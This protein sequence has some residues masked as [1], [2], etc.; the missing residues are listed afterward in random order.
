MELSHIETT[1]TAI[2]CLAPRETCLTSQ[3]SMLV[4]NSLLLLVSL[5]VGSSLDATCPNKFQRWVDALDNAVTG[6]TIV[7]FESYGNGFMASRDLRAGEVVLRIPMTHV[8]SN[9]KE[10]VNG[11]GSEFLFNS[12]KKADL[13]PLLVLLEIA[14]CQESDCK[15]KAYFDMLPVFIGSGYL[16]DDAA[17]NELQD[18]EFSALLKTN[19]EHKE[20]FFVNRGRKLL[21]NALNLEDI[22]ARDGFLSMENYF[23][24]TSLC[25]SRAL[26]IEGTKY[27]VP[28]ADMFN[29]K[30]N[31]IPRR[32]ANGNFFKDHHF[33]AGDRFI[34]KADRSTPSGSQVFMDYGDNPNE[35]YFTYHGFVPHFNPHD[36]IEIKYKLDNSDLKSELAKLVAGATDVVDCVSDRKFEQYPNFVS[37]VIRLRKIDAFSEDHV[38]Q[39]LSD[40]KKSQSQ[41]DYFK[42]ITRCLSDSK[43]ETFLEVSK[44]LDQMESAYSSSL[45]AD[46]ENFKDKNFHQLS[47]PIQYRI[48]RKQLIRDTLLYLKTGEFAEDGA[49]SLQ[50]AGKYILSLGAISPETRS[51]EDDLSLEDKTDRLNHWVS[52]QGFPLVKIKAVPIPGIRVGTIAT[53]TILIESPYLIVP[54]HVV[55]N[56]ETSV[57]SNVFPY[58]H[59]L[60]EVLQRHDSFHQLLVFLM[61]ENF[62][63][64]PK[65]FW[66]PYL[67]LLPSSQ[68]MYPPV[69]YSQVQLQVL[70]RHPITTKI[71]KYREGIEK[72][73]SV[74]KKFL[75]D[76]LGDSMLPFG[77]FTY[78]NYL[79]A[80]AIL[81]SRAIWWN[82]QRHLVPL[83]DLVNCDGAISSRAH[84]T[85]DMPAL[86]GAV[87]NANKDYKVGE[88][89]FENYGQPNHVYF[90]WHGFSL[91]HNEFD[92]IMLSLELSQLQLSNL[93]LFRSENPRIPPNTS[94][95]QEF[96]V[97]FPIHSNREAIA[98]LGSAEK[99]KQVVSEFLSQF[100]T[101]LEEN[102]IKLRSVSDERTKNAL[103]FLIREKKLLAKLL[104]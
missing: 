98:T 36:C 87:T 21:E 53:E 3:D 8:L 91:E 29:Y 99:L 58:L 47:L 68:E 85:L 28:I 66:W 6:I 19:K 101:P 65:S 27:L 11:P 15:W 70:E 49:T 102:Q 104:E 69:Y 84:S 4:L 88:Q 75:L 44:I 81:D 55:M 67:S 46:I 12:A 96:C 56:L 33:I 48:K 63:M 57:N 83:L 86:G 51:K 41:A 94:R 30:S 42:Y 2:V 38:I 43:A 10:S 17:L 78:E 103:T 90:M 82:G 7:G 5:A 13:L 18:D 92:C 9:T 1:S 60:S 71:I 20:F 32:S 72:K 31:P 95:L 89:V 74:V 100:S 14:K 22:Q 25:D 59:H 37:K 26:T 40:I 79:W 76:H 52:S 45:E 93:F 97:K 34:V 23:W 16:L 35:I 24:A 77:V 73:F 62:V 64:G 61:F 80:H 50:A 39:C 54:D